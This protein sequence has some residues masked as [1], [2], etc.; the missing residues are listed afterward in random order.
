M[1][2]PCRRDANFFSKTNPDAAFT[3]NYDPAGNRLAELSGSYRGRAHL[4]ALKFSKLTG[5][6]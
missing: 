1:V 6:F 4:R 5:Y 2:Q 3:H